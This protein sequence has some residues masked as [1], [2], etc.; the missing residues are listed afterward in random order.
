MKPF[1]AV[2]FVIFASLIFLSICLQDAAAQTGIIDASGVSPGQ[3]HLVVT[4]A[5]DGTVSAEQVTNVIKLGGKPSPS[6]N[7]SPQPQPNPDNLSE[8][9][10]EIK[11]AADAVRGD[12]GRV[13][14]CHKLAE[15]LEGI[16]NSGQ[17]D[18]NMRT[19]TQVAVPLVLAQLG[20]QS[21][22]SDFVAV[23]VR[24]VDACGECDLMLADA[25]AGLRASAGNAAFYY[26]AQYKAIDFQMIMKIVMCVLDAWKPQAIGENGEFQPMPETEPGEL[27]SRSILKTPTP[28][29]KLKPL[30][31]A[32]INVDP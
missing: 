7:P 23:L 30:N 28:A 10:L 31:P 19:A 4:V 25:V 17:S 26:N 3:Y 21:Q 16:A 6:P 9:A 32:D 22:W 20:V 12:D 27:E 13:A 2:V 1:N 14:T 24:Q 15:I 5:A 29:V 11:A 18:G 8:R